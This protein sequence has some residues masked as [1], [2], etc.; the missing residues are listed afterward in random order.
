MYSDRYLVKS[1]IQRRGRQYFR[2]LSALIY[3]AE[4]RKC[5]RNED[6]SDRFFL[7]KC[8]PEYHG[9]C[10]ADDYCTDPEPSL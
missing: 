5:K 7:G 8:I 1:F 9:G 10:C 6:T 2:Y 4:N 3:L